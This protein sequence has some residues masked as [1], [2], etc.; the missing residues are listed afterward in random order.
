MK[1]ILVPCDFSKPA[2][3]AFRF[4]VDIASKN[5]G[6]IIL[7]H[8]IEL[9]ETHGTPFTPAISS[10][11]KAYLK[12]AKDQAEKSFN[13]LIAEWAK[14][15]PRVSGQ[16]QYGMAATA[17]TNF[18]KEK[19]ADLIVMGTK[20]VAIGLK[21]IVIG[22]TT[23]RIIRA[24]TV[25]VLVIKKYTKNSIKN[26]VLA[27]SLLEDEEELA[28]EVNAL[29]NLFGATLHIVYINT[30]SQFLP[31]GETRQRLNAFARRYMFKDYTTTVYNDL[32]PESGVINFAKGMKADVVAIA[33]HGRKGF[34]HILNDSV[35]QIVGYHIECPILTFK[36]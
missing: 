27:S 13:K 18:V 6:E 26:I 36:I 28:K 32:A 2:I 31:D 3:S 11:E 19:K 25:P 9:L 14:D 10:E 29:Q 7:L 20:G 22:S 16:I 35:A 34:A 12:E 21:E 33:T 15:G 17:I 30:P 4:A 1:K 8:V 5:E 24:S 23:E